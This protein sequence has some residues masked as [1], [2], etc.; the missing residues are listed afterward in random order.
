MNLPQLSPTESA[1]AMY[2][3]LQVYNAIVQSLPSPESLPNP[4]STGG[5]WY[6]SFYNF[7]SIIGNDFKSF[8]ASKLELGTIIK[9]LQLVRELVQQSEV[10]MPANVKIGGAEV[11]V[12]DVLSFLSS[13]QVSLT[14]TTQEVLVLS[15]ILASYTGPLDVSTLKI[16]LKEAGINYV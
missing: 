1:V 2:I 5:I 14:L 15:E 6:R 12:T 3:G 10:E 11:S 9:Q 4:N 16:L 7:L 13:K 8:Y